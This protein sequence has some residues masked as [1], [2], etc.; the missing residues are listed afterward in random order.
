MT[1]KPMSRDKLGIEKALSTSVSRPQVNQAPKD[2]VNMNFRAEREHRQHW[3]A[4]AARHG[5]D[6]SSVLREYLSQ[7]YGLP[8]KD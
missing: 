1:R 5:E 3:K 6:L 2:L 8:P 4:E 7:R